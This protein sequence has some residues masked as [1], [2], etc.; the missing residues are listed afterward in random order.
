MSIARPAARLLLALTALLPCAT[1]HAQVDRHELGLRLRAFERELAQVT[2]PAA[3]KAAFA[4][5]QRAVQA[6]FGLDTRTVARSIEAATWALR[7][8][9]PS[10][11]ERWARSLQLV[12]AA[13]LVA[14][15]DGTL[16]ASLQ[17]AYGTNDDGEGGDAPAGARFEVRLHGEERV[18]AAAA[19][20]ELPVPVSMTLR[21][22]PAG[23]HELRWRVLAGDAVLCEREQGL[24]LADDLAARLDRLDAVAAAPLLAGRTDVEGRTLPA[25]LRMLR[26]MTKAR[27]EETILPGAR[28]LQEAEALAA[29]PSDRRYYDRSRSGHFWLRVPIGGDVAA[30]RLVVPDD[31]PEGG[32]V[33]LV[34]ALHGA[35]GSENLFCD[36]Y[37][38]GEIVRQCAARKWLL[39]APRVG[40][41]GGVDLPALAAVLGARYPV[42]AE[43]VFVVGHS[44][45]AMAAC[46][47]VMRAP[48]AFAAAAM[49]GGGG[50]VQR[51]D[52]LAKI[53][54]FV[55]AGTADFGRGG[56]LQ[57]RRQ[58]EGV[59]ATVEFHDY[60]DVEHLAV[61]QV[62]LPDVFAFFDRANR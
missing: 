14:T 38:N 24:S 15:G 59:G 12:P 18:L 2:E 8:R 11:G 49:L 29:L 60:L 42:D 28:L 46:A 40:L 3:R 50:A 25:L 26:G 30:L 55:G 44:M 52:G 7:Q 21:G 6:F 36:G 5:L 16:V 37:G 10:P 27:A 4:Q 61:V 56:A 23:D 39:A 41:G 1:I 51:G 32:R 35:G 57:L 54:F 13:R 48:G 62:A 43:R 58:L 17:R 47:Q 34:L 20:A 9:E 19:I 33:P 31:L 22:L 45:G 53:P